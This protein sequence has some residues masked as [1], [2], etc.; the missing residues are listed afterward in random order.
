[1]FFF[2]TRSPYAV[3]FPIILHQLRPFTST[4]SLTMGAVGKH[5]VDTT[6]RIAALRKVMAQKEHAVDALVIPSEDQRQCS[7][8]CPLSLYEMKD[9]FK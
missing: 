5:R 8:R 1:M 6:E 2:A 7:D 4:L 3:S 9:R